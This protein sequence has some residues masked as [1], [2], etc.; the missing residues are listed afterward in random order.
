MTIRAQIL[1]GVIGLLNT[2]RPQGI[3]E[4]TSRRAVEGELLDGPRI[5]VFLG[6]EQVDQV[7]GRWGPLVERRL[8]IFV[9]CRDVTD[10]IEELDLITEPLLARATAAL[11][12]Q[13]L[14]G[15]VHDIQELAIAR[16]PQAGERYYQ[17]ATA[18]FVVN[19]QTRRDDQSSRT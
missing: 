4:A 15:L 11:V 19:Y 10:R 9:Q 1:T 16:D 13:D 6:P 5:G 3:P 18:E 7:G 12:G 8:R 17:V 2:D 14:D